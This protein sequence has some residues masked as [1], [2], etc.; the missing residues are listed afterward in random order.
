MLS[1]MRLYLAA[2][3][4]RSSLRR[5]ILKGYL[6]PAGTSDGSVKVYAV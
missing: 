4:V 1:A 6:A 2:L 3:L 5:I